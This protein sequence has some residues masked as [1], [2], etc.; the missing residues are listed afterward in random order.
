[1][2]KV[3]VGS[4]ETMFLRVVDTIGRLSWYRRTASVDWLDG[5]S[6]GGEGSSGPK[7]PSEGGGGQRH[8][9]RQAGRMGAEFAPR[10]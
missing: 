7:T 3:P 5:G 10:L 9:S 4:V 1:M 8:A 2:A 6:S